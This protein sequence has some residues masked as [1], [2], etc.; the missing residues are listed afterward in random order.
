MSVPEYT[1]KAIKE[2]QSKFDVVQIRLEK[3]MKQE[4]KNR[5]GKNETLSSYIVRLIKEDQIKDSEIPF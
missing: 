3:G 4:I 1:K 2:Y 5:L